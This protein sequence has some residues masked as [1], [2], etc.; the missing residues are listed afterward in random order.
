MNL[1]NHSK[2]SSVLFAEVV[3]GFFNIEVGV[4]LIS[5]DEEAAGGFGVDHVEAAVLIQV[6]EEVHTLVVVRNAVEV[7]LEVSTHHLVRLS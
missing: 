6:V 2:L 7:E 1:V 5:A 3:E 4:G